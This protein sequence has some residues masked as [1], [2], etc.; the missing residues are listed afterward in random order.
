VDVDSLLVRVS[1]STRAKGEVD[2]L[3]KVL[4][5]GPVVSSDLNK[6]FSN[7]LYLQRKWIQKG[8][9]ESY[10]A[11]M[12]RNPAGE[13]LFASPAPSALSGQQQRAVREINRCLQRGA[14][15]TYLLHGVTGSGKTEVYYQAVEHSLR[16]GR[17]A[18]LMVPE[19][20]L[21]TYMESVFRSRLGDCVAI[22]HSGLSRGERYDQWIRMA[23]G[24]VNLVIGA[25]SAL[26]S[27]LPRVG[28]IIVDEEHDTAYK[29]E[30]GV[31][32]QARD[33][34]I[35]RAKLEKAVAILGSGT[36]SV[37][38]FQN[39]SRGR[40]RRIDMPERI[41][42]RSLPEV[43]VVDMREMLSDGRSDPLLSPVL[44]E[45]ISRNLQQGN[46]AMLFLNRRGFH[47]L[48][49]CRFCG[50]SVRCPNCDVALTHHLEGNHL[51]CHY[52]GFRCETQVTCP[53]CGK[54]GLK[55][56]G[57]GTERL[58]EMLHT[59]FPSAS[60]ARMDT[61]STRK[62]GEAARILKGFAE[63][64]IDIL[65]GTQMITK[66]YNFP[67]VTLVGV[68]AA[69]FSLAFPDFRGGERTFQILSQAAGRS[70]RGE[71]EGE[72][73]VQTFNPDHYAIRAS[74]RHDYREFF[75]MEI[76][77]RK[78]LGYP[79]FSHLACVR[80]SGNSPDRTAQAAEQ[81]GK[82]L[83]D[84][85]RRWPKRGKDLHVLGPAEAPIAKLKGKNRW[86][87]LV[88]TQRA[89]LLQH[90]LI[91]VD[92]LWRRELQAKGVQ[93]ILDVD[94]YQML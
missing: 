29:Q 24:E 54:K 73:I 87:I 71:Q 14:F 4:E 84:V 39:A 68:I 52:C 5:S 72:V 49:L 64:A 20:S 50:Q 36:P 43:K 2:F 13:V 46:Q 62:K 10:V 3:K 33:A 61:D 59:L 85:I 32:Y 44:R 27:P 28:L 34:A 12:Y 31:R 7:G 11:E 67:G 19:I 66:G 57:F 82:R 48:Y 8:V 81:M 76:R 65:V 6:E 63:Q 35:V 15:S 83:R 58:E 30:E 23:R 75:E 25:R 86:Q 40:Y 74:T 88:K 77:L 80:L 91:H 94:P 69:D 56:F 93:M 79:P 37:Q 92:K 41:E 26:F 90:L 1:S 53:A 60:V 9:L 47:R 55:A 21:A 78:E 51:V 22:Y 17:R 16:L 42:N 70:G 89:G 38:S 18:I 45:A